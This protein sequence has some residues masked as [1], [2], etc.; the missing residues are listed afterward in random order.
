MASISSANMH[1]G[2]WG[3]AGAVCTG[4]RV[5]S[6]PARTHSSRR[7]TCVCPARMRIGRWA[8]SCARTPTYPYAYACPQAQQV[9]AIPAPS[10]NAPAHARPQAKQAHAI[11]APSRNTHAHTHLP[12]RLRAQPWVGGCAQACFCL[13]RRWCAPAQPVGR[14]ACMI[15]AQALRQVGMRRY[16]PPGAHPPNPQA[17]AREGGCAPLLGTETACS[18]PAHRHKGR[19][20]H[21]G[22]LP[23]GA[24]TACTCPARRRASSAHRS[25]D[26]WV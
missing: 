7:R 18:C 24:A 19:W 15:S 22:M 21:V 9:H 23:L 13:A 20:A 6:R 5:P 10:R 25:T 3:R 2:R 12:V 4:R 11:S 16:A 1:T 17:C 14:R 8:L 26:R